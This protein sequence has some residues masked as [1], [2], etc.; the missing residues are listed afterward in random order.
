MFIG[1]MDMR[2]RQYGGGP[3]PLLG[4]F[5]SFWKLGDTSDAIGSNTL[6]N[7]A[8]PVTF[9]A[10]K[11]GDAGNFVAASSE[12]LTRAAVTFSGG[13]FTVVAWFKTTSAANQYIVSWNDNAAGNVN[14]SIGAFAA[15]KV[16]F[17]TNASGTTDV[18]TV[19]TYNDGNWH[20][21][22]AYHDSTTGINT[23]IV[24]NGTPITRAGTTNVASTSSAFA[25]GR[26]ADSAAAFMNGSIDAVGV[27]DGKVPTAAQITALWNNGNGVEPPL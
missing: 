6:T 18:R 17:Y 5:D 2:L 25:I 7:S 26:Y 4:F 14:L 11:I 15:G 21:A 16:A 9:S 8:N 23:L 10:G 19:S 1:G 27:A 3:S 20:L 12:A 13:S 22:I 24:D